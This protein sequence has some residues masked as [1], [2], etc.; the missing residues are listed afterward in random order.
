MFIHKL[1]DLYTKTGI[2]EKWIL[3]MPRC[4][5]P[6]WQI[7]HKI[8]L[9]TRWFSAGYA[10]MQ[11]LVVPEKTILS[12]TEDVAGAFFDLRGACTFIEAEGI[13]LNMFL[14]ISTLLKL[15]FRC[16]QSIKEGLCLLLLWQSSRK[17]GPFNTRESKSRCCL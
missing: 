2:L 9:T 12:M 5:E 10:V 15:N 11:C 8:V 7:I 1:R 6:D 17:Q 16:N 14:V 3:H 4:L 13:L